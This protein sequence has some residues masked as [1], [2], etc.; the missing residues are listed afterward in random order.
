M[1]CLVIAC[2]FGSRRV[3]D[4]YYINDPLHYVKWQIKSL[5]KFQAQYDLDH[6]IFV[7]NGDSPKELKSLIPSSINDIPVK[8]MHRLNR[9]MSYGAWN[10]AIEFYRDRFD[11]FFLL[12]D[13]YV[14]TDHDSILSFKARM[15]TS[16]GYV[17]SLFRWGHAAI[18]N[19]LVR[20]EAINQAGG[21]EFALNSDYGQNEQLGQVALSR[22][23]EKAGWAVVD[24]AGSY[25]VPFLDANGGIIDYG[26]PRGQI[27]ISPVSLERSQRK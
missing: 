16:V 10:H 17:C 14:L 21:I 9:G 5:S 11:F 23:I 8:V 2:Y 13:D 12:E 22:N 27:V 15:T 6:I 20:T 24:I 1:T 4:Q 18:S 7:V 25:R 26:Q 3:N 19:G